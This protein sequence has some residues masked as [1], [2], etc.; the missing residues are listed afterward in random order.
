MKTDKNV[1]VTS[2]WKKIFKTIL[3][4][5][6]IFIKMIITVVFLTILDV[7][8]PFLNEYALNNYFNTNPELNNYDT[9]VIFSI[10]YVI[11]AMLNGLCVFLFIYYADK[12]YVSCSYNLRKDAYEK[13]QE[14]PFSYYD[15]TQQ[16][17]LMARMTSDSRKLANIISWTLVDMVWSILSMIGILV[18]L[19]V[20]EIRLALIL[21]ILVP[22]MLFLAFFIRKY[23]LKAHRTSREINSQIT[24]M[25][26]EGFS[27][28]KTIKSLVIE[29]LNEKEF[30]NETSKY[31]KSS[32]R[33]IIFSSLLGPI[34]F[35]LGYVG[36]SLTVYF[37]GN[38]VLTG[39]LSVGTLYLFIDYT[40]RFFDPI[41]VISHSFAEFQNAQASAERIIG[42][43]ETIPSI[44][45]SE[46]VISKYGSLLE[47]K[48]EN[49]EE[50]IGDVEFDNVTF[51]YI[52]GEEV[53]KDFSLKIKAGTSVA[54]VGHT[55]SGKS[56]IINLICRFY[57]PV[58][59]KILIDN[60]DY[61]ERSIGWLH[62]N[63]GYVLQT[64]QLF[65]GT[66][67][68]NIRY[69]KLDA[70]EEEII[71]AAKI[72]N[73]HDFIIK[74]EKGYQTDIGEGG[75]KLSL[76]QKQLISIARA[77]IGNPKL[78]ILDEATSSVDTESEAKI[79]DAIIKIMKDKTTFSVAHRLSTIV[80]SDL[81]LVLK[82]GKIVE[83]GTHK[84]LLNKKG[85]YFELYRNQFMNE[86]Q[87]ST[88]D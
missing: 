84:E 86:I 16:G 69:G 50:L 37:G 38:M 48:K 34:M 53:L 59:G 30:I 1:R 45:D 76:G 66:I 52:E 23:I 81:I 42:L 4:D 57:E 83:Q 29:D 26:N 63:I 20:L 27:G 2:I 49:Y 51:K 28:M 10:I 12:L 8:T 9:S 68:D 15:Q 44:V 17:W 54:L 14:L 11:V 78:L 82:D 6:S 64:P 74:M 18:I 70:S 47:P 25:Y 55:G 33:A 88:L 19:I 5:K 61:K 40:V 72:A 3:K 56:T 31:R 46:E 32:L 80:N 67:A 87:N 85:Y 24:A 36:V 39:V 60:I 21:L 79:Q 22:V 35:F 62:S 41:F 7:G 73:A 58:G 77:I 43:I 75:N 13:L 71:E 65:S